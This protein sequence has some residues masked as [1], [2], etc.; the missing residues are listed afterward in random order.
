MY[1]HCLHIIYLLKRL[2]KL[3]VNFFG[4]AFKIRNIHKVNIKTI[5]LNMFLII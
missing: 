3:P 4:E 2:K 5:L 1:C